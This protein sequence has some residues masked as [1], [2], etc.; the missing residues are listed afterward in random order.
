MELRMPT[1]ERPARLN[2]RITP[3][4]HEALAVALGIRPEEID[5]E[6]AYTALQKAARRGQGDITEGVHILLDAGVIVEVRR[7]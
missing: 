7:A 1:R 2:K 4:Q 6:D 3:E 5:P